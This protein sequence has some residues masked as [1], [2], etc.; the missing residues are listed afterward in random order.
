MEESKIHLKSIWGR[1]WEPIRKWFYPAWLF[2]ETTVRFYDYALSAYQYVKIQ[3]D[4]IG[5]LAAQVFS[6]SASICTFL[7]CFVFLTIPGCFAL[8]KF[9]R[10]E[11]TD[12][13]SFESQIKKFF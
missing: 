13:A 8:F 5:D 11:T 9:F 3:E 10:S 1:R 6:I 7:I 4:Y 2:Y 12:N